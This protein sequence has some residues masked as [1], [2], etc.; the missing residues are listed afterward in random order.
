LTSTLEGGEWSASRRGRFTPRE[1]AP[2]NHWIGDFVEE[3][4]LE[5]FHVCEQIA[6][7]EKM[8]VFTVTPARAS[9]LEILISLPNE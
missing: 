3:N 5:N 4:C 9:D 6:Q 1:R 7:L 8:K 2:G